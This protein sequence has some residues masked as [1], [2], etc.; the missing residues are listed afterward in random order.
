MNM[1]LTY[2]ESFRI[3]ELRSWFNK[4]FTKTI[5]HW[6]NEKVLTKRDII[7]QS[8]ALT[9]IIA[10][11][12]SL[13]Y[14]VLS[15]RNFWRLFASAQLSR[16]IKLPYFLFSDGKRID[17]GNAFSYSNLSYLAFDCSHIST[18]DIC[19]VFKVIGQYKR[20]RINL[21]RLLISDYDFDIVDVKAIHHCLLESGLGRV[22]IDDH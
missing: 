7:E 5:Y 3:L 20:V 1:N 12:P 16:C 8:A 19:E 22:V 4:T 11:F 18:E 9:S 2:K 14:E 15:T 17:V 13:Y 6:P 21:K 10:D